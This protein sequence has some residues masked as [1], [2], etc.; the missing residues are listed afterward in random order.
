MILHLLVFLLILDSFLTL[1]NAKLHNDVLA[2]SKRSIIKNWSPSSYY[3]SL[4]HFRGGDTNENVSEVL[5]SPPSHDEERYSRQV[6]T[7]G[8]RAHSLVRSSTILIDGPS[9]SGLMYEA[10]KNLALSGVGKIII[11]GN[12]DEE[13]A[14]LES[15]YHE[16]SL[17]DLG[18]VYRR[19]AIA[20]CFKTEEAAS[21]V[22]DPEIMLEYIKRLNPSVNVQIMSRSKVLAALQCEGCGAEDAK[23]E[24]GSN[25]VLL[26]VDRP[27]TTQVLLNNACRDVSY[28]LNSKQAVPFVSIET[29]GV[30]GKVFCDFG[31][32]FL[33]EDENGEPAKPTLFESIKREMKN[34]EESTHDFELNCVEGERH[35][36]SKDDKIEFQWKSGYTNSSILFEDIDCVVRYVKNPTCFTIQFLHK[37]GNHI[38]RELMDEL[39]YRINNGANIFVRVKE[40]KSISFLSLQDALKMIE[41]TSS[42]LYAASDLDK[43]FDPI[44]RKAVMRSFR[45]LEDHLARHSHLV[46]NEKESIADFVSKA[47]SDESKVEKSFQKIV[48]SFAKGAK[49]KFSPLQAIHGALAAQEVLK[50]ASGLYNPIK[51]FLLYDCDEVL[52]KSKASSDEATICISG[53]EYILGKKITH[54][55]SSKKIFVVGSG[56]IGCEILKNLAAME[57]GTN[58][59]DGGS[60][61]LTD[62]D[63]I[64]KSN[65]SRQLL[66][67]D[68]DVGKFKSI[69]AQE[70]IIRMNSRVRIDAHTS[71]VGED[72]LVKGSYF[73][74]KFWSDGVDIVLN[75]LDNME[76]RLFIDSQCVMNNK[77]L[78]DAGT[79]GAKGN[80]QVVVPGHSES[81]GSSADP[82]EPTIPV[83]TL[84]NF[85]YEISHTIQ[86]GRDLFDG[87]FTRR[88][89]QVNNQMP[90]LSEMDLDQYIHM[91]LQKTGED[92]A[93]EIAMELHEDCVSF[94]VNN[95]GEVKATALQWAANLARSLFFTSIQNLLL[96]H[97]LDSVDEDGKPFWSGTR[98]SP[99]PLCYSD[100]ATWPNQLDI[101]ENMINF[102]KFAARLRM[103]TYLSNHDESITTVSSEEA[104]IALLASQE[105]MLHTS[106]SDAMEG[107][108]SIHAKILEL[109]KNVKAES[110]KMTNNLY[111]A[112]FEKDEDSNGHVSFVTASSN[113]RAIA[114][115]IPPV[116]AMETR[117][118]AGKIV[119]AM[120]T[121]TALVSALS[122]VELIKL[123]QRSDLQHHR[124]AFV[125]LA[126][127]FFAFTSPLPADKIIGLNGSTHTIWDRIVVKERKK[128][129]ENGGITLRRFIRDLRKK[130]DSIGSPQISSISYGPYLLYANF[131]HDDDNQMLDTPLLQL[132]IDAVGSD[133]IEED[134]NNS[135]ETVI[136]PPVQLNKSDIFS[137]RV[138]LDFTVTVEDEESGEEAELPTVRLIWW[139]S[140]L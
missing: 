87:L 12:E 94:D 35:D 25:P 100:D 22:S 61:I 18:A 106:S 72:E 46:S 107:S 2:Q 9:R 139:K 65:L 1:L 15:A 64:E 51:Q 121:T 33:V 109:L 29:A 21:E 48:K 34:S 128:A 54:K 90:S 58:K 77:A 96:K 103:E 76:A 108:K 127:P 7:L 6:Y 23:Q 67:R 118:V 63:T 55:L 95:I 39:F 5:T 43:S 81:Y 82:P 89:T 47:T 59:M 62:M 27:L 125:N 112:E 83:C 36:V 85:P 69:A 92:T 117:R 20:E 13:S 37:N 97:P 68:S 101:N 134:E 16:F 123:V 104:R 60:L 41:D 111:V 74:D 66:F 19:S 88:P 70:A 102:V 122:C 116:D 120:I 26:C 99:T 32:E 131:L 52:T 136:T 56:A 11:V 28:D 140:D 93:L 133:D 71:K 86:W 17:D 53:L 119:P 114:Y 50:A 4:L 80:V 44:R 45:V 73:D 130:T 135:T 3:S 124:N 137:R 30:F 138:F 8:A 78:I 31:N 91:I 42:E 110:G 10:A 57:V 49:A 115:S 98:R 126:L 38:T 79:L 14:K 40:P 129:Y 84:K 105:G 132:V 113:L 24:I 75:A